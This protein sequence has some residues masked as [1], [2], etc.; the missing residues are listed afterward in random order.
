MER[1]AGLPLWTRTGFSQAASSLACTT[2]RWSM[3]FSASFFLPLP[4]VLILHV[5]AD[6]RLPG[7]AW[8]H[9]LE[10]RDK[11]E[12]MRG[13]LRRPYGTVKVKACAGWG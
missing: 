1:E 5:F 7:A 9:A 10:M 13:T 3:S 8:R 6:W 11:P 12:P 2:T 4:F